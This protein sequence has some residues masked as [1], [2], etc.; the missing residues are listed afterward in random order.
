[1]A[2]HMTTYS[3]IVPVKPGGAVKALE[4]LHMLAADV[5]QFEIL[6]AEGRK[7]S[8]QRN[9]AAREARGEI[10][11]FL[12]DDSCVAPDCLASCTSSFSEANVAAVGGPSLTPPDDTPLQKLFGIA[13][14]SLFGA[15]G[16]RNRYR[17]HGNVRETTDKELILCNL[18]FKRTVFLD[19]GGLDERLYPNEENE[20]LDRIQGSGMKLLHHPDM[21]VYRS[22]RS[23]I[24]QFAR[25][26][27]SYGR[28]RAQQTLITGKASPVGFIPLMFVLYL[29]T[30]PF[31][32]TMPV[33][34]L[35]LGCYIVLNLGFTTAAIAAHRS[36]RALLLVFLFPLMHICNGWGLLSGL[37]GG[38]NGNSRLS[39]NTGIM[40]RRVK[41]FGQNEW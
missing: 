22:Q 25:Q 33:L 29:L 34:Y 27:Y 36:S 1:M 6:V 11:Y 26:M 9:Q 13:L 35:P 15:G 39:G 2:E 31:G 41:E 30:L 18:A 4:A 37:F 20:L 3:F 28:G 14:S 16:M 10:L 5:S 12:D 19:A 7:P 17:R 40:I 23:S 32:T 24:R 38:R 8:L 21:P